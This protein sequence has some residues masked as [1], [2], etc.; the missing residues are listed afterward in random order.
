MNMVRMNI[1]I[2]E[3]LARR[4]ND[5]VGIRGKSRFIA[6]II[7]DRIKKMEQEEIERRLEEGYRAGKD[8]SL[9]IAE[10]FET[11]DLEGWD[12]Y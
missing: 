11:V 5:L 2:P 6:E 1:T 12:E 10:E 8:E 3:D 7:K 4:L 9:S